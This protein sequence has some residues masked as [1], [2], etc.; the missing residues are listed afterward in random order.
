MPRQVRECAPFAQSG[1][2]KFTAT[3]CGRRHMLAFFCVKNAVA[4]S[5]FV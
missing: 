5:A 3:H 2:E 4:N 1:I